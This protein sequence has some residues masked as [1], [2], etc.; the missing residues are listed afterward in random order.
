[1]DTGATAIKPG[2]GRHRRAS[3]GWESLT[4]AEL[5]VVGLTVEGLTN[6]EIAARLF[7]SRR[8]VATHLEHV[9]EKLG[10]TT[11]VRVA[12]EAARRLG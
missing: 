6:R 11:R 8:T 9:F 5:R 7:V 2:H 3:F 4:E 12:A 10:F 1:M